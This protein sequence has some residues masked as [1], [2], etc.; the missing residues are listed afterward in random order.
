MGRAFAVYLIGRRGASAVRRIARYAIGWR[1]RIA[2]RS[3]AGRRIA[4]RR[5]EG[6]EGDFA[7]AALFQQGGTGVRP[8][9]TLVGREVALLL[10]R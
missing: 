6:R 3:R 2:P 4:P 7:G 10:R 5:H 9:A 8:V 1:G